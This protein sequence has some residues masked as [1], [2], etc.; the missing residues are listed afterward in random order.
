VSTKPGAGQ[1][2]N[3]AVKVAIIGVHSGW[4]FRMPQFS[5]ERDL[6]QVLLQDVAPDE[7]EFLDAYQAAISSAAQKRRI[8]TG[9]GLPP[10]VM[11]AVGMVAVL[12]SR[13]V[14]EK[15]VEW[16]GTL[17]GEISKKFI[18]DAS[19]EKV[20]QWLLEPSKHTLSGVLTPEGELEI[21]AIVARDAQVAKLST[22]DISK[23]KKS[24]IKRLGL[25]S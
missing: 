9:M 15:I 23:L 19:V 7:A 1:S 14:F 12:V 16:A 21:L 5:G 18:V 6:A 8:G 3:P 11:G 17:A 24:V 20:K 22:D 13:S 4:S 10:E 2:S 25:S